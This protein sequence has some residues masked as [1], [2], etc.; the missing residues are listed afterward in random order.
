MR[1]LAYPPLPPELREGLFETSAPNLPP[2]L[3]KDLIE[4]EDLRGGSFIIIPSIAMAL[5]RSSKL[6]N[7]A[8]L[9]AIAISALRTTANPPAMPGGFDTG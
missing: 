7:T 8:A 9:W 2:R 3:L 6:Q 4:E 1:H 5:Q